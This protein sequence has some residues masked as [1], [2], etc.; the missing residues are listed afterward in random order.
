MSRSSYIYL[1]VDRETDKTL[2]GFTVKYEMFDWLKWHKRTPADTRLY[3]LCGVRWTK[4]LEEKA[5]IE[6]E[7][8]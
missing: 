7:W 1:A 5:P 3:R 2:A 4:T 6:F 8:E